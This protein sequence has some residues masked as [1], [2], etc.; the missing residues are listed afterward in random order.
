[1]EISRERKTD[2]KYG[3]IRTHLLRLAQKTKFIK[4]T[5]FQPTMTVDQAR[6]NLQHLYKAGVLIRV[7]CGNPGRSP[8]HSV[9]RLNV[10]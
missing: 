2:R 3:K 4:A 9:Y 6:T 8:K 7:K 10:N 1:M 5:D